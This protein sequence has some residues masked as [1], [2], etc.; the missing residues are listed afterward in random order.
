LLALANFM[1]LSLL[2]AAHA[3]VGG[4]S[5]RK[6]GYMGRERILS[7]L[8]LHPQRFLILAAVFSPAWQSVGR[9]FAPS[10]SANVRFGEYGAPPRGIGFVVRE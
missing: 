9:S 8:S 2:K 7:M 4:A 10:F 6:S 3:G 5:Y 1:W